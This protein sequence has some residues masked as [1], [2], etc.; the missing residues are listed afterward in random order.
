MSSTAE[1]SE[2]AK[3]HLRKLYRDTMSMIHPD[4]TK[5]TDP[6]NL[7][8][9][10]EMAIQV[11]QAHKTGNIRALE[12][13]H[14]TITEWLQ[15][16]KT[17]KES[18]GKAV[19]VREHFGQEIEK[20]AKGLSPEYKARLLGTDAADREWRETS[21]KNLT[22]YYIDICKQSGIVPDGDIYVD[23]LYSNGLIVKDFYDHYTEMRKEG[24]SVP[25]DWDKLV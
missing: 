12:N 15:K 24:T 10:N 11:N 13:Y 16:N 17:E 9:Y 18:R 20:F 7:A 6:A 3:Q 5:N 23:V 25:F 14:R 8:W 19:E 4:I 22:R 2:G 21:F 1:Q